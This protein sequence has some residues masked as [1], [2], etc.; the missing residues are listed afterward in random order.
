MELVRWILARLVL[1]ADAMTT[2]KG[3]MRSA[4]AQR[5]VDAATEKLALYQFEACPFCVKVRRAMARQS[6]N[7]ELRDAR[8][9]MAIKQELVTQG[10]RHKV[11]CLRVESP[12]SD[13]QW[14]YESN[15]IIAYLQ[16]NFSVN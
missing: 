14:L 12:D 11:P 13:D 6:L 16:A 8:N 2:P 9:D 4:K 1:S 7:I 15:D 10:G 5:A 3:L